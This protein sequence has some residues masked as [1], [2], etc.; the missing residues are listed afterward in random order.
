MARAD[1]LLLSP[2]T[3]Q[4]RIRNSQLP[5]CLH[6]HLS[7]WLDRSPVSSRVLT[8]MQSG[9]FN[10]FRLACGETGEQRKEGE[11]KTRKGKGRD[12]KRALK[13]GRGS[14]CLDEDENSHAE[15]I[16]RRESI[17]VCLPACLPA[18]MYV[19]NQTVRPITNCCKCVFPGSQ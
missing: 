8:H 18:C 10:F 5:A 16:K 13:K 19:L 3:H 2:L 14:A 12:G 17:H 1:P 6:D 11:C 4:G 9:S 15:E 7:G